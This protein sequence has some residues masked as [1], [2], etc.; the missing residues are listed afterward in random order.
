MKVRRLLETN[1]EYIWDE[2]RSESVKRSGYFIIATENQRNL[3]RT[4]ELKG[5]LPD[6]IFSVPWKVELAALAARGSFQL[7]IVKEEMMAFCER[8]GLSSLITVF[9]TVR[10]N[11]YPRGAYYEPTPCPNAQFTEPYIS[12]RI[13]LQYPPTQS[14]TCCK[15]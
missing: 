15:T 7:Q 1:R 8:E 10:H 11:N 5:L 3:D 6:E 2:C 14:R 9:E 4:R 13:S 12:M